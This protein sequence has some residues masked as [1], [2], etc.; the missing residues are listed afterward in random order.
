M[1][2]KNNIPSNKQQSIF[3]ITYKLYI[4]LINFDKLNKLLYFIY[5]IHNNIN[6]LDL[7][8]DYESSHRH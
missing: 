7:P 8:A 2:I 3:R 6:Q 1:I 5:F 4:S